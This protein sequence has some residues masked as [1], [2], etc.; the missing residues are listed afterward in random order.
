[1]YDYSTSDFCHCER[2]LNDS[3]RFKTGTFY[4]DTFIRLEDRLQSNIGRVL[5][6]FTRLAITPP[7]VNRFG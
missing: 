7:K 3:Y 6:V 2:K 4:S 1:M 5:A